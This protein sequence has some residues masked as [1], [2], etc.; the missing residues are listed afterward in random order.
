MSV[1]KTSARITFTAN[2]F[3]G[4]CVCF[5]FN[6]YYLFPLFFTLFLYIILFYPCS[7]IGHCWYIILFDDDEL[8]FMVAT[9]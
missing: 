9:F 7:T 8:I 4:V 6:I 3:P 1:G 5:P 2:A